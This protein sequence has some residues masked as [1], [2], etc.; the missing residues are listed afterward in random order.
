LLAEWRPRARPEQASEP[1]PNGHRPAPALPSVNL[2]RLGAVLEALPSEPHRAALRIALAGIVARW[3]LG[4][5]LGSE[6]PALYLFGPRGLGKTLI[7]RLACRLLGLSEPAVIRDMRRET[8]RSLF[9]WRNARHGLDTA[10]PAGLPLLCLDEL[11]KIEA[12]DRRAVAHLFQGD[13]AL[14]VEGER[15]WLRP[16]VVATSNIADVAQVPP[17]VQRRAFALST[18]P[19]AHLRAEV[20]E[21]A[22]RLAPGGALFP[23]GA[24]PALPLEALEPPADAIPDDTWEGLRS[25][26]TAALDDEGL[27]AIDVERAARLV[28]G[29]QALGWGANGAAWAVAA[30]VCVLAATVGWTRPGWREV[31]AQAP[32]E[33]RAV[34]AGA[35]EPPPAPSRRALQRHRRAGTLE[36]AGDRGALVWSLREAREA[37]RELP[38]GYYRAAGRLDGQLE[39]AQREAAELEGEEL[40]Q[41][42]AEIRPAV[43]QAAALYTQAQGD[44]EDQGDADEWEEPAP[45]SPRVRVLE[46][47]RPMSQA[48]LQAAAIQANPLAGLFVLALAG[49]AQGAARRQ[50]RRQGERE[51]LE[52]AEERLEGARAWRHSLNRQEAPPTLYGRSWRLNPPPGHLGP[53]EPSPDVQLSAAEQVEAQA[54]AELAQLQGREMGRRI[55]RG[56]VLVTLALLGSVALYVWWRWDW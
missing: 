44:D 49:T 32:A 53:W 9:G 21:A 41:L 26:F 29:Y 24:P 51:A 11:D 50:Q 25:L 45:P 39:Q 7:V 8:A 40:E 54:A 47:R 10:A 18:S 5:R 17:D 15:L 38:R 33:V 35:L 19:M 16:F 1:S 22:R 12:A 27:D 28:L 52:A 37:L 6:W 34:V 42:E 30:D 31:F 14:E 4:E 36:V 46:P 56:T 43:E 3:W 2:E 23:K 55:A 13:T 20:Q 48:E